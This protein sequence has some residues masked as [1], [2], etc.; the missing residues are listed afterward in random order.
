MYP[1]FGE[2]HMQ[3]AAE[4]RRACRR[5][6]KRN[7]LAS[8]DGNISVRLDRDE[9]MIT[10]SGVA[11]AF[12]DPAEMCVINLKG[13]LLKG[14]ASSERLMHLE[15]YRSCPEAM[16]VVHAHPPHAIAWSVAE[17]ELKE[18]PGGALSE[19]VLA[20]GRI[21]FVPYARPSTEA[22]GSVLREFLPAHRL[23]ILSRHGGLA[24]G[25]SLEEAVNGMERLEHSAQILFLA[26]SLGPLNLLPPEEIEA[27]KAM[28]AK[29]GEKLL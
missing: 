22:M 16:A 28:R 18:L 5:L 12:M 25:E 1:E 21:P 23:M 20:A 19:V 24:W 15:V 26:R 10:P 2:N 6:W 17:P 29:M 8:A 7:M 27:L 11:K 3:K 14:Q 13:E 9:I 4:I